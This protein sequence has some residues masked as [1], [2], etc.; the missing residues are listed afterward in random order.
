MSDPIKSQMCRCRRVWFRMPLRVSMRIIARS[1]HEAPVG[2]IASVLLVARGVRDDK[3]A[4]RGGEERYGNCCARSSVVVL[5]IS[6]IVTTTNSFSLRIESRRPRGLCDH[7]EVAERSVNRLTGL[8]D[9][10]CIEVETEE[11]TDHC[12]PPVAGDAH[13]EAMICN[14]GSIYFLFRE[15]TQHS[16]KRGL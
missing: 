12:V 16:R 14:V 3:L 11:R 6:A 7:T 1:A 2:H 10:H 9:D 15:V 5:C 13:C 4:R 8:L